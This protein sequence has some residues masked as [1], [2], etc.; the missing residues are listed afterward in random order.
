M[1]CNV[2]GSRAGGVVSL[3]VLAISSAALAAGNALTTTVNVKLSNYE[4]TN[5][6]PNGG[7][8]HATEA[9]IVGLPDTYGMTGQADVRGDVHTSVGVRSI[10]S[11]ANVDYASVRASTDVRST[12]AFHVVTPGTINVPILADG[13]LT[14]P[15]SPLDAGGSFEASGGIWVYIQQLD[16]QWDTWHIFNG[17]DEIDCRPKKVFSYIY[18]PSPL[19]TSTFGFEPGETVVDD[20]S[21]SWSIDRVVSATFTEPGDYSVLIRAG[22]FASAY[23]KPNITGTATYDAYNTVGFGGNFWDV[24]SGSATFY[25]IDNP[26]NRYIP[27]PATIVLLGLGASVAIVRRRGATHQP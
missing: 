6:D 8:Q 15:D 14:I 26:A 13:W 4:Y 9:D 3:C 18:A 19:I 10:V 23:A 11:D 25:E 16:P 5:Y 2:S 20:R 12:L 21:I 24:V 1:C 27:E 7:E 17:A 22:S